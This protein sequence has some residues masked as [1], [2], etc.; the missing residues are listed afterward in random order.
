MHF[1]LIKTKTHQRSSHK[2]KLKHMIQAPTRNYSSESFFVSKWT[3]IRPY[4]SSKSGTFNWRWKKKYNWRKRSKPSF[5]QLTQMSRNSEPFKTICNIYKSLQIRWIC[6][7][8]MS[9]LM[10][11][12]QWMPVCWLGMSRR[13]S[14][15]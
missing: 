5:L 2:V 13:C 15:T 10:L 4:Q 14:K 6:Y 7:M 11:G 12:L 8:W 9:V 1:L 3:L